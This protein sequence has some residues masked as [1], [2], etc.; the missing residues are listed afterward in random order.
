MITQKKSPVRGR[1]PT[2]IFWSR[3]ESRRTRST[4]TR[5]M[6]TVPLNCAARWEATSL[7]RQ[8][9]CWQRP[10]RRPSTGGE[11]PTSARTREPDVRGGKSQGPRGDGQRLVATGCRG[12]ARHVPG[13]ETRGNRQSRMGT[14]RRRLGVVHSDG[15]AGQDSHP[16][17]RPVIRDE[18]GPRRGEEFVSPG[19]FGGHVSPATIWDWTSQ[20]AEPAGLGHVRTHQLRQTSLTT[21][22]DNTENLRAVSCSDRRPHPP[23][24]IWQPRNTV[25]QG[26]P[27]YLLP[28]IGQYVPLRLGSG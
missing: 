28:A 27:R 14:L 26:L 12:L 1:E 25:N 7:P 15:E 6:S 23:P 17:R 22:L 8:A 9:R 10:Q 21:A 16:S 19:R 5:G 4:P 20:V 3:W 24:N 11:S 2:K 18:L 13:V